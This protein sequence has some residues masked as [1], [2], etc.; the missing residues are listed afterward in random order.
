[1]AT[2]FSSCLADEDL[3]HASGFLKKPLREIQEIQ[4][5]QRTGHYRLPKFSPKDLRQFDEK[6]AEP[7][8][9]ALPSAPV[10][11]LS[12][13]AQA[14]SSPQ[15]A[16]AAGNAEQSDSVVEFEW[17]PPRKVA[18]NPKHMQLA[19][20]KAALNANIAKNLQT[21]PAK[22]ALAPKTVAAPPKPKPQ[23]GGQ[24][25]VAAGRNTSDFALSLTPDAAQTQRQHASPA[26]PAIEAKA[27]T[28]A[29]VQK[30][31]PD[32]PR[33]LVSADA[34]AKLRAAAQPRHQAAVIPTLD[35]TQTIRTLTKNEKEDENAPKWFVVQLAVSD[36]PANLDTM[37]RLDIFEA[38]RL[39]S[40][41]AMDGAV[42]RHTLR[43][44]F[45]SEQVS[46]EAVMGYLKT[47]FNEPRIERV[48]DAE[49]KRFANAPVP[50]P[51]SVET[52]RPSSHVITLEDKRGAKLEEATAAATA[53]PAPATKPVAA[54]SASMSAAPAVKHSSATVKK[55]AVSSKAS[56]RKYS[57]LSV[58]ERTAIKEAR[59][60]G[61]SETGIRRVESNSLLSRLVDKL[62]K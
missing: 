9:V 30:G 17:S 33:P 49:Q 37:P 21:A 61:L 42:I 3:K 39:Y 43:L 1:L 53:T 44:G 23:T 12:R 7:K 26:K 2:A 58:E 32:L 8:K 38:Y 16:P 24:Y 40:V 27:A 13:S 41:A 45:F 5:L 6:T 54:R 36:Q 46:A 31:A 52:P 59:L 10:T 55:G 50:K 48:S 35:S 22:L 20:A 56:G 34:L 15:A 25:H 29:A 62:T 19:K 18:A 51:A 57:H 28:Q 47:F 4:D 14:S 60:L 11:A